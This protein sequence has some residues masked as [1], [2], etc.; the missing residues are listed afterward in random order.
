[1]TFDVTG[2][3]AN[4]REAGIAAAQTLGVA[5]NVALVTAAGHLLY[6]RGWTPLARLH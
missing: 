5:V 3:R 4:Q 1:M 2:R 6:S